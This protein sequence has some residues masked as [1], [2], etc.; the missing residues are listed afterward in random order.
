MPERAGLLLLDSAARSIGRGTSRRE[1]QAR[2]NAGAGINISGA[3]ES[4]DHRE[5][6]LENHSGNRFSTSFKHG[7]EKKVHKTTRWSASS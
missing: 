5:L 7:H 3:L 4:P 2:H 1:L 6:P